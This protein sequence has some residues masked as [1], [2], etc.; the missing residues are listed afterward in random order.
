M[1]IQQGESHARLLLRFAHWIDSIAKGNCKVD[2]IL[3]SSTKLQFLSSFLN[4][5]EAIR[6]NFTY[7]ESNGTVVMK[8]DMESALPTGVNRDR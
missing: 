2:P 5:S 4:R 6:R 8:A 3:A 7:V 1:Q